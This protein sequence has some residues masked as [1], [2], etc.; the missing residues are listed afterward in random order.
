MFFH[1]LLVVSSV[2]NAKIKVGLVINEFFGGAGTTF[3][4]YGFL[5]RNFIAKYI[6]DNRIQIDVLL[7]RGWKGEEFHEDN[8]TLYRLPP[9]K[10]SARKFLKEKNYDVYLSIELTSDYVLRVEPDKKKKLILWIQDPRPKFVWDD[11]IN[12]MQFVREPNFFKQNIY[13]IVNAWASDRRV[14]FV[15]Q[16]YSLIPRAMQLYKR[17]SNTSVG[18]LPNPVDIDFNFQFDVS[19]KKKQVMFLGRLETQ[20]RVWI[21]CEV[22]K[23]MPEYQF[24]VVGKLWQYRRINE[25]ILK[26]YMNEKIP[27]LHFLGHMDGSEKTKILKESRVLLNTAIWEGIPIS[28]LEALSYGT[29]IVSNLECE[30]LVKRFGGKAPDLLGDGFDG[31][32]AF[33]PVI[34]ELIENDEVYSQKALSAIKYVR[35]THNIVRFIKDLRT[36]IINET[37]NSV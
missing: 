27:N 18:Y 12:T 17:P 10:L 37:G 2:K 8:I 35:E 33:I 32:K 31:I 11:I 5:A 13:D 23:I 4:G 6:P 16:G 34:R 3:G 14:R 24:F 1:I 30:E 21:F 9:Q 7:G 22:A 36:L 28:W 15:S 19:L 29:L 20:K 25:K 26:P